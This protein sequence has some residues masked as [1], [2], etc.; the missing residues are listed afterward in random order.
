VTP[1]DHARAGVAQPVESRRAPE[2]DPVVLGNGGGQQVRAIDERHVRVGP[3][4]HER[5]GPGTR[6]LCPVGRDET[7]QG[8]QGRRQ[9][10]HTSVILSLRCRVTASVR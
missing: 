4:Q 8:Q 6:G 7:D 1:P 2:L 5:I 3:L 10:M 9:T